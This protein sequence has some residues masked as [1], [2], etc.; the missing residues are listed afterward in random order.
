MPKSNNQY[1]SV[2][3]PAEGVNMTL[4]ANLIK[5]QAWM[6]GNNVRFGAG[7]VS[8]IDGWEK[9]VSQQL[10][11]T[12]C[13]IDN[14]YKYNGDQYLMVITTTKVYYYNDQT[15]LFVDI[16]GGTPLTG[17]VKIPVLTENAQNY[18]IFTNGVDP[19]KYWQGPSSG[20]IAN[21]P[22]LTDVVPWLSGGTTAVVKAKSL[23]YAKNFLLLFGT[24]ETNGS[25]TVDYPQR[26]RWSS[27][28]DIT[29][30]KN[31]NQT[32]QDLQAGWAD[33]SDGVDWAQCLGVL[34]DY[35]VAYKE[36]SIQVLSY[37]GG[38]EIWDKWPAIK[39]VGLLAPK[40]VLDLG[41]KHIFVGPANLYSFD[42]RDTTPVGDPIFKQFFEILDPASTMLMDSYYFEEIPEG[43]FNFVSTTSP[44]G[45]PDKVLSYN[46]NTGAWA[47]RDMPMA[48]FGYYNLVDNPIWSMQ[49][50]SWT[51]DQA[52]SPWSTSKKL[53]NAP[54]NI[55]GDANGYIYQ[56]G[57]DSKDGAN[58]S[59]FVQTKLFDFGN[60]VLVKQVTRLQL[61]IS[62][63]GTGCVLPVYVGVAD[64]VED[65]IVWSEAYNMSLDNATPP[66]IDL[67]VTGRYFTFKFG[68]TLANQPW[69]LTG[70]I[71]SYQLRGFV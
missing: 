12:I 45:M 7:Y 19:V 42:L 13:A 55:S 1:K 40:A 56:F 35:V 16:T 4:P 3:A 23:L 5:D 8:K 65:D 67:D 32:L 66:W 21:L 64:N 48:C 37:V 22:G 11:G 28:G 53:A 71:I 60:P 38:D 54:I 69:K 68:T 31:T 46:C 44:D 25:S 30:W 51:D 63:E 58:L 41:D 47:W 10:V 34:G 29:T 20:N 39:G 59:S 18:F 15:K 36:R 52:S 24:T 33:L 50:Y 26:L 2:M 61:M 17:Q 14:Y 57:G 43:G 27:L 62:H 6:D 9:F 70:Y 49:D